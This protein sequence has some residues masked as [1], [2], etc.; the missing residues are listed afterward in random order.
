MSFMFCIPTQIEIASSLLD[1][2]P[3]DLWK[4]YGYGSKSKP[5][6][7]GPQVSV[8]VPFGVPWMTHS[9]MFPT[10]LNSGCPE[11]QEHDQTFGGQLSPRGFR[12][13]PSSLSQSASRS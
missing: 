5:P 13:A 10:G 4:R 2:E 6:G 8:L 9:H 1:L 12:L 7:I 11:P 3:S